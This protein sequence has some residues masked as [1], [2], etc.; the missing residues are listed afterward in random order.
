[1]KFT[2]IKASNLKARAFKQIYNN[3]YFL[4]VLALL[5]L[6]LINLIF[7]FRVQHVFYVY[8]FI[9]G[10]I[11]AYYI[12]KKTKFFKSWIIITTSV[13][14]SSALLILLAGLLAILSIPIQEWLL[15]IPSILLVPLL[16]FFPINIK[17]LD[18]KPKIDGLILL[19]FTVISLVAHVYCIIEYMAP[20]LHDPIAHS[21]WAKEIYNTGLINYFYSPG[22][23]ILS[24]L[25]MMV[26]GINVS[27]YILIITN[28]FNALSFLPV[29]LFIRSYFEDKKFALLSSL[30]FVLSIFPSKFFW[31]AG[32]NALV[33]AIPIGFLLLFLASLEL[34]K[35]K[36]L[37]ILNTL[38]FVLILIHYPV[39]FI[40]LIGAFFI[41]LNK[42]NI[43]NLKYILIG[44]AL[45]ILWGFLKMGYE[46][47]HMEESIVSSSGGTRLTIENIITF[48][49]GLYPQIT[50]YL[51]FPLGNVLL[52]SGV[53]GLLAMTVI[54]LKRKRY[55]YFMLF[56]YTNIFVLYIINF[57]KELS[58]LG[59]VASTQILIFF[60]F[61]YI[62][63]AF[64]FGKIIIPY[65]FKVERRL[66]LPFYLLLIVLSVF[67]NYHIYKKY[68]IKQETLNMVE[69][70]DLE[71]FKWIVNN[72]DSKY[73]ILNNA[74][75]GNRK[76]VVYA[77]DAG[78][79]IPVFTNNTIAMPFTEFSAKST[80]EKYELY[81]DLREGKQT[82]LVIN[83]LID[84]NITY[85]Y[86]GS[87]GVFGSQLDV[88][89]NKNFELVY[90]NES[91]S[92]YKIIPCK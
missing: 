35:I 88:K 42:N 38:V 76:S 89:E 55:L 51:D 34:E 28:I 82:C 91:S 22:L 85:Y 44:C 33:M 54:V 80:H 67:C 5:L 19:I 9:L 69:T 26:D 90:S 56:F 74:Q 73:I 3:R 77:S 78:A 49:K 46:V 45:G 66:R 8:L 79:R 40:F 21:V 24:A 58:F 1:M 57:V 71:A 14:W 68:K 81:L 60:I 18:I 7:L 36:K 4:S 63:A 64:L 84:K 65:L 29:Y 25:G 15:F 50:H 53:I 23:H 75:V 92:L 62:G 12:L 20:I 11:L 27:K 2:L 6:F 86:K 31:A 47:Q 41:L 13:F 48:T 37:I 32:K 59:I 72:I 30:L 39:A 83:N 70:E 10:I 16:I 87:K 52:V 61:I 17:D 43:K